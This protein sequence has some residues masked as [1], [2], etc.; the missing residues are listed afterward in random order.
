WYEA[1][2]FCRWLAAKAQAQPALLPPA[3]Q[4]QTNWRI[5]LPT[6]WQWEKAA[7]GHDGRQYPWGDAYQAGYTNINESWLKAGPNYLQKTSAVGMYP[8]GVSPYGLLDMSGNVRERCLNEYDNPDRIQ[9]E[10]DARRVVRGGSWRYFSTYASALYRS[11]WNHRFNYLG[12]RV[13]VG[14]VVPVS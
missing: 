6:E 10:G 3:L 12:F 1:L 4:G 13:V 7:R 14:F 11:A 9:A 8:H 2:A 5:T